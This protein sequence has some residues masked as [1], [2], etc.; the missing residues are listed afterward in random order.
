MLWKQHCSEPA[1]SRLVGRE[2]QGIEVTSLETFTAGC[3]Q[4]F[5]DRKGKLDLWRTAI[6]GRCYREISVIALALKGREKAYYKRL[7]T[8]AGL[9][10]QLVQL[11]VQKASYGR[12]IYVLDRAA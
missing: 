6:L 2:I 10:L 3:I 11:G 12:V 9:V 5:M 4:T 8:L 7:E 1:P